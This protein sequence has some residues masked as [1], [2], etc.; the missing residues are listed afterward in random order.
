MTNREKA[1]MAASVIF[2]VSAIISYQASDWSW[3]ERSGSLIMIVAL[4]GFLRGLEDD[5]EKAADIYSKNVIESIAR[6]KTSNPTEELR[7]WSDISGQVYADHK[8]TVRDIIVWEAKKSEILIG[9]VGT[10]VWGWGS[11]LN[12]VSWLSSSGAAS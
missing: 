7:K 12:K 6:R 11:L 4:V 9:I 10:L 2:F 1:I 3:F 8:S 5:V